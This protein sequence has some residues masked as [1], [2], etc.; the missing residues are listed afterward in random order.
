MLDFILNLNKD[1][2]NILYNKI[3]TSKIGITGGS[4]GGAGCIRAVTEF[5]NGKY[6]KT[7]NTISTPRLEMAKNLKW[8]Y[9]VKK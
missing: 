4:Q 2:S 8:E 3:D 1:K 9:D 7:L 5:E 6:Y